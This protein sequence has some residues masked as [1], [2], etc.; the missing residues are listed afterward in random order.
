MTGK[1]VGYEELTAMRLDADAL[2]ALA[3]LE[4]YLRR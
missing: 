1:A 2:P 3:K 4:R